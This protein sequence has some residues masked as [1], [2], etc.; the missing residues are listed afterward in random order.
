MP[1]LKK[2]KE[3]LWQLCKQITRKRYVLPDGTW[4]CYT[5]GSAIDAPYK[6]HT[7]HCVPDAYGGI[8]LRFDLRN[9]RIQDMRC[10]LQLGGMGA[11]YLMRLRNEIGEEEVDDMFSL[12]YMR[13][14]KI[15]ER[16]FLENKI[17][18]YK[19]ILSSL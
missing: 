6:A 15:N 3:E 16:E 18:E 13:G 5:C 17:K 4:V 1:S 7:G 9:L 2:L 14:K 10:N 19:L 8:L 11:I 12:L